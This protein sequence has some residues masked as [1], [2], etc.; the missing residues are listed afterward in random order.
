ML[1]DELETVHT[2]E[3]TDEDTAMTILS[4]LLP[5][6][7]NFVQC[8]TINLKTAKLEDVKRSLINEEK[9]RQ[10]KKIDKKTISSEN[11]QIFYMKTKKG[12]GK[13]NK[14]DKQCDNCEK[15]GHYARDVRIRCQNYF[16]KKYQVINILLYMDMKLI[17]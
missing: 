15:F 5:A 13:W 6:Y 7:E 10:E 8:L 1:R 2:V 16:S 3:V 4:G 14:S 12:K 9:R 11:E 17:H